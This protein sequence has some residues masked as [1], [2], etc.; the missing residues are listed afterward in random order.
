[1]DNY[2]LK[3][4][5]LFCAINGI[6]IAFSHTLQIWGIVDWVG[7]IGNILLAVISAVSYMLNKKA[8]YSANNHVFIRMVYS[9]AL[10]KL[11][12]CLV[13]IFVYVYFYRSEVSKVTI[14]LL[15]FLYFIYAIL[16]TWSLLRLSRVGSHSQKS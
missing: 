3:L 6:G 2:Y 16:E 5:A 15:M 7:A 10:I 14:F 4:I 12:F 1:M 8:V 11:L 9:S 13:G